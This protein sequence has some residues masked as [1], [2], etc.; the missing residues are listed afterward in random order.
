MTDPKSRPIIF[1]YTMIGNSIAAP[2]LC[3]IADGIQ[4]NKETKR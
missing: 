1:S 3:R 2:V 4:D